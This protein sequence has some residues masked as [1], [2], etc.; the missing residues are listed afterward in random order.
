[1]LWFA[2]VAW[3]TLP[4]TTGSTLANALDDW[5]SSTRNVAGAL[6]WLAFALGLMGVAL[7][8]PESV[9]GLRI[10]A[11]LLVIVEVAAVISTDDVGTATSIVGL[12][13]A[14]AAWCAV[15]MPQLAEAG[16]NALAYG[17]ERRFPLKVPPALF[18]GPLPFAV[19]ALGA[20]VA[21]GPLLLADGRIVEAA[22]A[23]AI[24]VPVAMYLSRS[25]RS[26]CRRMAVI[27]PAGIVIADPMTLTDPHLFA[28]ERI[29]GLRRLEPAERPDADT[30]D[31]RSGA[32]VGSFAL[33]LNASASLMRSHPGRREATAFSARSVWFAPVRPAAFL[34]TAQR[35]QPQRGRVL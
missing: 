6:L 22:L 1:M 19:V 21:T 3:A 30:H 23:I 17:D 11:P 8:R 5:S 20:S 24:G 26:L 29:A 16:L 14:F 33:E 32:F 34:K 35:L 13:A 27:V 28:V 31:T 18:L 10:L 7:P 25:F 15:S 12:V 2:R 4:I 9:L